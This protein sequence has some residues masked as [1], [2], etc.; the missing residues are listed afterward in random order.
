MAPGPRKGLLQGCKRVWEADAG[1]V[2]H[3]GASSRLEGEERTHFL[4]PEEG[5]AVGEDPTQR[6]PAA[7]WS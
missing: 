5:Y 1:M 6:N 4:E 7:T 2:E 3:P